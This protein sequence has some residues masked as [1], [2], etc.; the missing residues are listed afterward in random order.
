MAK[1][2]L[3]EDEEFLMTSFIW[4]LQ[5]RGHDLTIVRDGEEAIN[6]L[7]NGDIFFDIIILDIML[8]R[9]NQKNSSQIAKNIKSGEMG[10]EVLRHLREE[11]NKKT[12]V[13]ALSAVMDDDIKSKVLLLGVEKYFTKPISLGIFMDEVEKILSS[14]K[15]LDKK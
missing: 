3:I 15:K 11:M 6:C 14:N 12:P 2:L 10:V 5:D 8:P 13:I 1:I 4:G 7:Q 9:G